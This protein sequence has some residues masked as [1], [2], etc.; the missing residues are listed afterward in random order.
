[1]KDWVGVVL[2]AGEGMRM[3]SRTPKVLHQ[4]CGKPMVTYSVEALRRAGIHDILLVVAPTRAEGIRELFGDTVQYVE[5][6]EPL[7]TGHALLQ[8][9]ELL[10][11]EASHVL[12]MI[13]DAPL[14]HS[15]T[16]KS[17]II[18]RTL[19]KGS[20]A[21]MILK[22]GYTNSLDGGA[23][24]S[25]RMTKLRQFFHWFSGSR[26]SADFT[27]AW[28]YCWLLPAM[29]SSISDNPGSSCDMVL[30]SKASLKGYWTEGFS[31]YTVFVPNSG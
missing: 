11:K 17:L 8:C 28:V 4:V 2:A 30:L 14:V 24:P 5:Q 16:I 18:W 1:M 22:W 20:T 12:V 7:G 13:G 9:A 19:S 31:H 15:S 29:R 27:I 6:D 10:E 26:A 21:S 25:L 3:R 23:S